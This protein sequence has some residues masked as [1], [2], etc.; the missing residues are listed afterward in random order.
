ME[1]NFL[2]LSASDA[3]TIDTV[4][5]FWFRAEKRYKSASISETELWKINHKMNF[6]LRDITKDV[7]P[8]RIE[9]RRG[10]AV[11][12]CGQFNNYY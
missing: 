12:S 11:V 1:Q 10:D 5:T 3:E 4:L 9:N 2:V 8:V 7:E 6:R